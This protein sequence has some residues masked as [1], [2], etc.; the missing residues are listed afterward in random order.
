MNYLKAG[1]ALVA[2]AWLATVSL[3]LFWYL[4][5]SVDIAGF[6][7]RA[8]QETSDYRAGSIGRQRQRLLEAATRSYVTARP[9]APERM[10]A[11]ETFA[12]PAYLNR[13]LERMGEKW[14][15]RSVDGLAVDVYEIS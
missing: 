6:S 14:R 3:T 15:V 5:P 1:L 11:G 2:F 10:V 4:G 8:A 7:T 13:E 9:N 12:P